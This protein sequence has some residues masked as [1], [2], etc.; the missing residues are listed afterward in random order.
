MTII[1]D[2]I[3]I[4]SPS[5][6]EN[7]YQEIKQKTKIIEQVD[8]ET[9][10]ILWQVT[11]AEIMGSYDARLQIRFLSDNKIK[12]TGSPH[13]FILGHNVLGGPDD[14]K[15][16]CRYLVALA[17]RKLSMVLPNWG[18]W[19]L[20]RADI[21][22]CFGFDSN[23]DVKDFFK[24]M[25]GATYPRREI[26]NY[27]LNSIYI[28]GRST[29]IKAYCKGPE[30]RIHDK[31]RLKRLC[32][33]DTRYSKENIDQLESLGDR[34]VRFEVEVNRRKLKY[35]KISTYCGQLKDYYFVN[36]YCVE[37]TKLLKEGASEMEIVRSI[38]DVKARL[39]L[40]YKKRKA[41]NLFGVWSRI[42]MESE[43]SVKNSVHRATW[44]R[45]QMDLR[46]AG[47]SMKGSLR[48]L[49]GLQ[50]NCDSKLRGFVPLPG[51]SYEVSGIFCD[52]NEA[53]RILELVA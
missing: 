53:I 44:Y 47:V 38:D 23:A 14:I 21:T 4:I 9:G 20:L 16:C 3:S 30:F 5:I 39:N 46:N 48:I 35:D 33:T 19:Q 36:V 25:R 7:I 8:T 1:Y 42:Q 34:L 31:S 29:T 17:G 2:T 32:E 6:P 28:P 24:M 12:I 27:G 50:V 18:E 49:P 13:K 26:M 41:A 22:Y 51:N 40:F 10:E 52:V 15:G 37:I 11:T 43:Q 45:Y